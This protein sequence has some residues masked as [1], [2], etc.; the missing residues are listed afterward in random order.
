MSYCRFS[1]NSF[2]SDV[3]VYCEGEAYVIRVASERVAIPDDL[4]DPVCELRRRMRGE[5]PPRIE[6]DQALEGRR[7]FRTQVENAP[8][9]PING[10]M[11]GE[12]IEVSTLD[13]LEASLE[14]L[15]TLGY[16]VPNQ[17]FER[18]D[19][20]RQAA[21]I[22]SGVDAHLDSEKDEI[23]AEIMGVLSEAVERR[24]AEQQG[25]VA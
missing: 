5:K 6:F 1:S 7:E 23:M 4:R 3:H 12:R 24:E 13:D 14:K 18:I 10:P 8:T 25:A 17:A 9:F 11:D 20:E 21:Q 19:D 15:K 16:R 2:R 22:S